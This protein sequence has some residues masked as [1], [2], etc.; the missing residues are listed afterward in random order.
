VHRMLIRK[1]KDTTSVE[2]DS[3]TCTTN[4]TFANTVMDSK[5]EADLYP[6]IRRFMTSS[7]EYARRGI[8]YQRGYFL[9]GP[10]GSGKSSTIKAIANEFSLPIFMWNLD[11][12]AS[13]SQMNELATSMVSI[14]QGRP[15]MIVFEDVDRTEFMLAPPA[16][17]PASSS[18]APSR[19]AQASSASTKIRDKLGMSSLLNLI[20]GVTEAHGRI[21]VFTANDRAVVEQH[22]A[23]LRPGRVDRSVEIGYCTPNQV[24]GGTLASR[25]LPPFHPNCFAL[26][27]GNRQR[28]TPSE[29]SEL[30]SGKGGKGN[31]CAER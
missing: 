27:Q 5:T 13:E 22:T 2:W 24:G 29:N 6:D 21:L 20:D 9:P 25:S 1:G 26:R 4:K 15:Y 8:P 31:E 11:E 28:C 14:V 30:A 18:P 7:E 3:L 17:G 19:R 23:L 12:L 10:P 16:S